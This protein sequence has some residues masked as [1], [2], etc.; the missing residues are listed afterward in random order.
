M[1]MQD[2]IICATMQ[3]H[4]SHIGRGKRKMTDQASGVELAQLVEDLL[5]WIK[6]IYG[7]SVAER[8]ATVLDTEQKRTAYEATDGHNSTR[9]IGR[10]AGVDQKT[11]SRWWR[12]WAAE[13]ILQEGP[14]RADRP[15]KLISLR[16]FG[17]V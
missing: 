2:M 6:L 5:T 8:L 4:Q 1:I 15:A 10:L 12:E 17:L 9:Q 11:I 14:E 13:A 3:V 16:T 7:P